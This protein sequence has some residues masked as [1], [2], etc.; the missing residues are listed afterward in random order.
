MKERLI[1]FTEAEMIE[2][3][4]GQAP[5]DSETQAQLQANDNAIKKARKKFTVLE[6]ALKDDNLGKR[7]T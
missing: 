7:A 5:L 1:S 4:G 3:N 6:G 2:M